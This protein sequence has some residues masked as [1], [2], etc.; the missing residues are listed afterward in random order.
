MAKAPAIQFYV[1]DFLADTSVLT[2]AC[3]GVWIRI[4]CHLHL[5]RPRGTATYQVGQWARILGIS[6]ADAEALLCEL[7]HSGC[8]TV[9]E[10]SA[11]ITVTSRRMVREEQEREANR[12][13]QRR[14]R[15]K[16][17]GNEKVTLLSASAS[18]SALPPI[19]PELDTEAFRK[20]WEE[21]LENRHEKRKPVTARAATKQFEQMV[22]AGVAG[23][24]A[25]IDLS[26]AN[27]WTGVFPKAADQA[28]SERTLG[29]HAMYAGDK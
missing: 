9:T 13:R 24:I 3:T 4:I 26:I 29:T 20:A 22:A 8:A 23:S 12:L 17:G 21:W 11:D 28:P 1:R 6:D 5:C 18:A 10:R 14:Y 15:D 7:K 25:A 16:A 27:G 19:P 2:A